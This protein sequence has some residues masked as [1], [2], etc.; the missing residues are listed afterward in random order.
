[1]ISSASP[2][3]IPT[4]QV[5]PSNSE[6]TNTNTP[7]IDQYSSSIRGDMNSNSLSSS[8]ESNVGKN[9]GGLAQKIIN[10]VKNKLE[11]QGIHFP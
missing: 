1:M 2:V 8:L 5:F 11:M 10:D 6:N 7:N 9:V 4:D 3:P